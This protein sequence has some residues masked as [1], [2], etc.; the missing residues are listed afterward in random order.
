[1]T[2]NNSLRFRVG[3][4]V[5]FFLVYYNIIIHYLLNLFPDSFSFLYSLLMFTLI[6]LYFNTSSATPRL[7]YLLSL[8]ELLYLLSLYEL[9]FPFFPICFTLI[10]LGCL[11]NNLHS[12][13]YIFCFINYNKT[14]DVDDVMN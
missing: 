3:T 8:Y 13:S 4:G 1:M 10:I 14:D 12:F 6:F 5:H 11:F 2:E 7:L 9:P